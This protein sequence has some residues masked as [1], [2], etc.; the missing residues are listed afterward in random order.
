MDRQQEFVLRSIEE[1]DIRFVRLWFTDVLGSLKSV[2][3][4]PAELEGAFAGGDRLR[5]VRDRGPGPGVR[6]RHAGQAGSRRR[7]RCC[8]GAVIDQGTAR[9]FCDILT[10]DGEPSLSDPRHV[11]RRVLSRAAAHGLTFYTHPEIEFYLVK[12]PLTA[13]EEPRAGGPGGLLRPRPARHHARLPPGRDQRAGVDGDL[14]GVQPP[15]GRPRAERDR[16]AL[17]GRV[18]HGRQHHDLPVRGQGGGA[19]AGRVR[20]VH[21]QALRRP[22]RV[23]H[24]HPPVAVRGRPQRVPRGGCPVPAEQGRPAVHR[25]PARH[26]AGDHRGDQP[27]GELLQ[28]VVG[29]RRGAR[30]HLLGTQQPLGA[31]PGADVQ[32]RQGQLDPDRVPG[33]RL[34]LQPLPRL[35]GAPLGRAERASRTRSTCPT[36]RRTTS[37]R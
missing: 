1:R 32:A 19:G 36:A 21:A 18:E 7:S 37:G 13:G 15:R 16:P 6:G 30:L 24:A 28:A 27:V 33:A 3:V 8:R 14:G 29:R 17:R 25:R 22:P 12:E 4:A 5:R 11:L 20:D 35:R 26:A 34:R 2:A 10:P 23:G 31:D 9:M